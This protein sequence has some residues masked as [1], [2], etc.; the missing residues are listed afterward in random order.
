MSL[1]HAILG[2]LQKHPM[3]GYD[4]KTQCFDIAVNHFWKADQA[5]IYRTLDKL[6][7]REWVS[8]QLEIQHDRPNRKVY[9]LTELGTIELQR[10]LAEPQELPIYRDPL[11]IQVFFG[12]LLSDAQ[13]L[14][15]LQQNLTVHQK[16]LDTYE[17]MPEQFTLPSLNDRHATRDRVMQRLVLEMVLNKE[18]AYIAWLELAIDRI[19][20]TDSNRIQ[21]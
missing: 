12:N 13:M 11:L 5:Q 7:E 10:W 18:R 19:T 4:L 14:R 20:V 6:I 17:A 2:L 15:L 1:P 9:S 3:T 21:P 8:N 16:L